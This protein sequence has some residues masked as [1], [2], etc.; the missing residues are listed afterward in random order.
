MTC[1]CP[2]ATSGHHSCPFVRSHCWAPG[3]ER[4]PCSEPSL[5]T[6]QTGLRVPLSHL[7]SKASS[8]GPLSLSLEERRSNPLVTFAGWSRSG[9]PWLVLRSPELHSTPGV[10]EQRW[11]ERQHRPWP[12]ANALPDAPQDPAALISTSAHLLAHFKAPFKINNTSFWYYCW[13]DTDTV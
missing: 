12:A 13:A 3:A 4:G 8:P 6:G 1:S 5:Q 9:A 11:T 7:L 2:G 10:P